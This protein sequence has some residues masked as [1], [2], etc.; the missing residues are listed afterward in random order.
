MRVF[1]YVPFVY[2]IAIHMAG[3]LYCVYFMFEYTVLKTSYCR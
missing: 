3:R 1:L 2:G